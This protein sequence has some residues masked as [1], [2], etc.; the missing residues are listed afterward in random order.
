MT[1]EDKVIESASQG[2]AAGDV[3][4]VWPP[5]P[6][7]VVKSAGRTLQVL[8]FFDTYQTSANV[9]EVARAL[10]FPQSS[11]SILLRSLVQ[12][13]YLEYEPTLRVYRPTA[14]VALLGSWIE[15]ALSSN[16]VVLDLLRGLSER[17]S[18]PVTLTARN[19]LQTQVIHTANHKGNEAAP[20]VGSTEPIL[21]S[22]GG[23]V[24]LARLADAEI[25]RLVRR[26]NAY[27]PADHTPVRLPE[28]QR[29]IEDVRRGGYALF[30]GR[31]PDDRASLAVALPDG[32]TRHLLA[33]TIN[34]DR[35][36]LLDRKE[37]VLAILRDIFQEYLSTP[38][39][40]VEASHRAA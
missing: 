25:S 3:V 14:R 24:F 9:V 6:N 30:A 17:T 2:A 5:L 33:V 18:C 8:E 26:V 31:S 20:A 7:K 23:H 39:P 38:H 11:T 15:P 16:G 1:D 35:A 32:V 13:G 27:G 21:A 36:S 10:C 22:A 19:G 12:M 34:G 28:L 29:S 37:A 40:I 4:R